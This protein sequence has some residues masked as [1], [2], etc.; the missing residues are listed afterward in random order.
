MRTNNRH[1]SR[2]ASWGQRNFFFIGSQSHIQFLVHFIDNQCEFLEDP[3]DRIRK[4]FDCLR[5]STSICIHCIDLHLKIEHEWILLYFKH[6]S[7]WQTQSS[8]PIWN[9]ICAVLSNISQIEHLIVH[10]FDLLKRFSIIFK[11]RHFCVKVHPTEFDYKRI[12]FILFCYK[13]EKLHVLIVR[14]SRWQFF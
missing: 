12:V 10:K 5:A 7:S 9:S 8:F 13:K 1:S 14:C 2:L 3:S 11:L 6:Y 4:R